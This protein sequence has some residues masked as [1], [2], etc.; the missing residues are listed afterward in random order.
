MAEEKTPRG[1]HEVD[2]EDFNP[3]PIPAGEIERLMEEAPDYIK[4]RAAEWQ[5]QRGQAQQD[6]AQDPAPA[7]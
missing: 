2:I 1:A 3:K 4:A 6:E 7:A 5:R